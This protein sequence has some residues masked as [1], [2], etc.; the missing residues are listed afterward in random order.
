M[1]PIDEGRVRAAF[2]RDFVTVPIAAIVPLKSLRQGALESGKY[3]QILSS[4]KAIGL[5]EA[6]AVIAAPGTGRAGCV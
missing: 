1:Q 4:I 3:G 5:V 2:D 6:P